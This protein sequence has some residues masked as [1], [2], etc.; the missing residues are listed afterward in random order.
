MVKKNNLMQTLYQIILHM[1]E[2]YFKYISIIFFSGWTISV[3]LICW[4]LL[5]H[6]KGLRCSHY[7]ITRACVTSIICCVRERERESWV[8]I[9]FLMHVTL[10]FTLEFT[11]VWLYKSCVFQ[12]DCFN[13]SCKL[14]CTFI[15]VPTTDLSLYIV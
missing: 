11:C 8:K 12:I 6:L 14:P 3:S 2:C 10:F 9:T 5:E 4:T 7:F 15:S 1:R 13:W